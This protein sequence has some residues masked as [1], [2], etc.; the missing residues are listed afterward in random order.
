MWSCPAVGSIF[1]VVRQTQRKGKRQRGSGLPPCYRL[2][3]A[4]QR[5]R[6]ALSEMLMSV[7]QHVHNDNGDI[8]WV[9]H[10]SFILKP[11]KCSEVIE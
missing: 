2:C 9:L 7:C 4:A 8:N 5:R 1:M 3:E 6:G 11:I 10:Y